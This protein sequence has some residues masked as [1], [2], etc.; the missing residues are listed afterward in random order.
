MACIIAE[1]FFLRECRLN[2]IAK[3]NFFSPYKRREKVYESADFENSFA[4]VS[5]SEKNFTDLWILP[6]QQI[7]DFALLEPGFWLLPLT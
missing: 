3:I 1:V 4:R 6:M 2:A 7:M 5:D